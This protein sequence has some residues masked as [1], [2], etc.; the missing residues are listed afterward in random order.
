MAS[1]TSAKSVEVDLSAASYLAADNFADLANLAG[2]E[3][4]SANEALGDGYTIVE[5]DILTGVEMIVNGYKE[6]AGKVFDKNTGE[7]KN[8]ASVTAI[9][10]TPLNVD[11]SLISKV[12]FS[13]GGTGILDQLS[14]A[15]DKFGA[16]R[17]IHVK[18]GLKASVYQSPHL[19]AGELSTTYYFDTSA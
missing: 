13:D 3:L 1:T 5:Q 19:P 12:R 10:R 7:V 4:V 15:T 9:L 16:F 8:Y 6:L 18:R 11:G 2:A 14:R 17:P